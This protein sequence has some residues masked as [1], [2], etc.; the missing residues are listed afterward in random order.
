LCAV[1]TWLEL[2]YSLGLRRIILESN[3]LLVVHL[4]TKN[5]V[6]V[7]ANYALINKV[8]A[9]LDREWEVKRQH[10]FREATAVA[11]WLANFG[12]TKSPLNRDYG[13]IDDSSMGL[14]LILY[15]DLIGST[16]P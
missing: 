5:I 14:F 15:Y 13:I 3:S 9:I 7:D 11:E 6:K 1:I 10:I 12:L 2:A 4:I 16:L 8:K